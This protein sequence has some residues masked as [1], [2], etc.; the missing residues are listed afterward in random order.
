MAAL[1][2]TILTPI[3]DCIVIPN[4]STANAK[5]EELR[6]GRSVYVTSP[7]TSEL[8]RHA[9]SNTWIVDG[10]VIMININR[11]PTCKTKLVMSGIHPWFR[12][13][14]ALSVPFHVAVNQACRCLNACYAAQKIAG[15]HFTTIEFAVQGKKPRAG[16]K[17]RPGI[18][19]DEEE[20]MFLLATFD[21]PTAVDIA[22]G[23]KCPKYIWTGGS[24]FASLQ[25]S[26]YS[27]HT[28][29]NLQSYERKIADPRDI[30]KDQVTRELER[31]YPTNSRTLDEQT[32]IIQIEVKINYKDA[33]KWV[34]IHHQN[35]QRM[36]VGTIASN[37]ALRFKTITG[38]PNAAALVRRNPSGLTYDQNSILMIV[39]FPGPTPSTKLVS[40]KTAGTEEI[41]TGIP[42]TKIQIKA[43]TKIRLHDAVPGTWNL[44]RRSNKATEKRFEEMIAVTGLT[45]IEAKCVADQL[46][47]V[48]TV[49]KYSYPAVLRDGSPY[50]QGVGSPAMSELPD[51]VVR[52]V[53]LNDTPD[54]TYESV[55]EDI[56]TLWEACPPGKAVL[57]ISQIL[58]EMQVL[59]VTT[60]EDSP[61]QVFSR[62]DDMEE[63]DD[64]VAPEDITAD[65]ILS[66]D[67]DSHSEAGS[68]AEGSAQHV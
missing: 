59:R 54:E 19:F 63:S 58:A 32:Y 26:T 25:E 60:P 66:S 65:N 50:E 35:A 16:D 18:D 37:I 11:G 9:K 6:F 13:M 56:R 33:S 61:I 29:F 62:I 45:E 20:G 64:I 39:A 8:L 21:N 36:D 12:L 40:V 51:I 4:E 17:T 46:I 55:V 52:A 3:S 42:N 14:A 44:I 23:S 7:P 22:T 38:K 27:T 67:D 30:A 24:D 31:I 5:G 15:V 57:V 28:T 2:I 43:A 1:D 49:C 41:I 47:N 34:S 68:H 48:A 53:T 10:K